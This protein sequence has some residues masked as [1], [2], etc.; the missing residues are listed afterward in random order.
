M[1]QEEHRKASR[2]PAAHFISFDLL[3]ENENIS[4]SGLALSQD[5]S[6]QGVLLEHRH[7]FPEQ[8][9]IHLHIAVGDQV[10]HLTGNVKHTEKVGVNLYHM[11]IQ[12]L[13]ATE[14][15][16]QRI[17]EFHPQILT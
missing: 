14:E 9:T 5:L 7:P 13:D 11:G 17:A 3:D 1:S 15:K 12:F 4:E 6:R 10:V 16:I 2:V 8:S